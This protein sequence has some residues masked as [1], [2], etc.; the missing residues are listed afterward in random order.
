MKTV[1]TLLREAR[2]SKRYSLV[3]VEEATKIRAKFLT[4]MEADD[5]RRLPSPSIVRGFVHNYAEFL[6]L[7]SQTVL[8]FLRRQMAEVPKSSL[9]PKGMAEPINRS[10]FQLTPAKFLMFLVGGLIGVFLIYLGLQYRQI[11]Q[12]PSLSLESPRD[13]LVI[14]EKRVEII[15]R[16]DPDA[17]VMVNSVSVLVRSDGRFFD[18]VTFDPGVNTITIVA[19]SRFGKITTLTREIGYQP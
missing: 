9:L 3:Q 5:F 2:E 10:M 13:Q 7:N 1:G 4:A 6:G 14:S 19:T 18:T 12:P 11:R 15:G 8:A 16:T 17:T